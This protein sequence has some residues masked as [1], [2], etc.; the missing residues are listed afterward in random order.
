[1]VVQPP[2]TCLLILGLDTLIF[3]HPWGSWWSR[4][5]I[6]TL[7]TDV[8]VAVVREQNT[9][10]VATRSAFNEDVKQ[11]SAQLEFHN[12]FLCSLISVLSGRQSPPM[13]CGTSQLDAETHFRKFTSFILSR[14]GQSISNSITQGI[15]LTLCCASQDPFTLSLSFPQIPSANISRSILSFA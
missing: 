7:R 14:S 5:W 11:R 12:L 3:L 9:G 1:M 2:G 8:G 6:E 10:G 13:V 4:Y 15:L